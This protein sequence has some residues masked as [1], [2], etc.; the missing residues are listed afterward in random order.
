MIEPRRSLLCTNLEG[1]LLLFFSLYPRPAG[2][3][4]E[5]VSKAFCVLSVL[6]N[7]VKWEKNL[8]IMYPLDKL[9][10]ELLCICSSHNFKWRMCVCGGVRASTG[11]HIHTGGMVSVG[12][13]LE[14]REEFGVERGESCGRLLHCHGCTT[15]NVCATILLTIT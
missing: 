13:G 12:N 6:I 5:R 3:F 7:Y 8:F 4:V 1:F 9:I 10:T 11:L 15:R 14:S 2:S